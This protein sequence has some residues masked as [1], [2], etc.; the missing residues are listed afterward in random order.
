MPEKKIEEIILHINQ[1]QLSVGLSN[2]FAPESLLC[3]FNLAHSPV[4]LI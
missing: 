3:L 2:P 4:S 1:F